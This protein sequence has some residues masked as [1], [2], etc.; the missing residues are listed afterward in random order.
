MEKEFKPITKQA[1]VDLIEDIEQFVDINDFMDDDEVLS[2][3]GY[4]TSLIAKPDVSM[5]RAPAFV[6][7]LEALATKFGIMATYY[8][9]INK[10]NAAKKNMYYTLRDKTK[11]LADA[12]KYIAR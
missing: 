10:G 9:S 6:V 5:Q 7:Q 1:A 8:T 12:V 2:V 3:L 11:D 4:V